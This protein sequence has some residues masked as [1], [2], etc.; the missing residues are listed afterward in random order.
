MRIE[1]FTYCE[2]QRFMI[3]L[4]GFISQTV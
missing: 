3:N 2:G 4:H 1:A